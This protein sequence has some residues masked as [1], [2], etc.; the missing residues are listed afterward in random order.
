MGYTAFLVFP[1]LSVNPNADFLFFAVNALVC[2]GAAYLF[3]IDTTGRPLDL[4]EPLAFEMQE[5]PK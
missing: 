3:P 5:S 2:A 4:H 1:L